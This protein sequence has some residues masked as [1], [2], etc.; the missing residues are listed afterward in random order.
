MKIQRKCL[1]CICCGE[2]LDTMSRTLGHDVQK[3]FGRKEEEAMP[4]T[5]ILQLAHKRLHISFRFLRYP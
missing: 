2:L 3:L 5:A 1:F 4:K